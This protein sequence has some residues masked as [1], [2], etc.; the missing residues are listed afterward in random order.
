M[1]DKLKA[2]Y[3]VFEAGKSV[4]NPAA[5]K[6]HQVSANMIAAFLFAIVTL[7]KAFGYDFGIDMQTCADISIGL[8]SLVNVGLTVATTKHIGLPTS[9]VRETQPTVSSVDTTEQPAT[10]VATDEAM[11]SVSEAPVQQSSIDDATRQRAIAWARQ[12]AATNVFQNDA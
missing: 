11:P 10:E 5:W 1:L 6:M 8:L 7:L 9:T 4:T 2:L 3:S 12:H